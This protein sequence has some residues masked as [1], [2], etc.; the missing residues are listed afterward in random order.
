MKLLST[1]FFLFVTCLAVLQ[2]QNN[3]R[4]DYTEGTSRIVRG[5]VEEKLRLSPEHLQ[6]IMQQR[7]PAEQRRM[8][9]EV[10]KA[11]APS[12]NNKASLTQGSTFDRRVSIGGSEE[13]ELHA[14]VNPTDSN[15][16]VCSAM[17]QAE[18]GLTF[19]MYYT[20]DFGKT[21]HASNFSPAP[22]DLTALVLGGG[23]PM[24]A[25]DANGKLYYSWI[26][27]Y[28]SLGGGFS[29]PPMVMFWASSTDGGANF[30]RLDGKDSITSGFLNLANQEASVLPDKQWMVCDLSSSP[31][32]NNVY[33]SL[34]QY[35]P[36]DQR[37]AMRVKNASDPTFNSTVL[38][39][40][41]KEY[42]FNQFTSI[43]CDDEG[44]P[45]MSFVAALPQD[46]MPEGE[47][48]IYHMSS[49]D[50]GK[51]VAKE[52]FVSSIRFLKSSS[53]DPTPIEPPAGMSR[54]QALPQI[55]CDKSS[56]S[57]FKGNVYLVWTA[58]GVSERLNNGTDIYF[59]RSTDHGKTWSAPRI[60]NND[61]QGKGTTQ[62]YAS[63]CVNQDGRI[64]VCW[65]D[66]SSNASN[67][68][69]VYT[70]AYSFDG[71]LSFLPSFPV[72]SAPTDFS[73]FASDT[74]KAFGM[75]EY[76]QVVCTRGYAI[77]FWGDARNGV[78]Q[79]YCAK[80]PFTANQEVSVPEEVSSISEGFRLKLPQ[81]NPS[82]T[83][84]HFSYALSTA[85]TI[86]LELVDSRGAIVKSLVH[87]S[88]S[89]GEYTGE[90]S[91]TELSS[92]TY[93]LRMR[94]DNA[95]VN[96]KVVVRH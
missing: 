7:D 2:A 35:Y 95:V 73:I 40:T 62:A 64:A 66:F 96:Q 13:S 69:G 54:I 25:F 47:F 5:I 44:V 91:V 14:A 51:T 63:M 61:A 34:L 3:T 8:L 20:K 17:S 32:R 59:S 50:H 38:R 41:S 88:L 10:L 53:G 45:H 19:P 81:P 74:T 65:Y 29:N 80:V 70:M 60:V 82:N 68:Q 90:C 86:S 24:F 58:V 28:L 92:G 93:F 26:D 83:N 46:S 48:R 84:L 71:G 27:L 9:R 15:N 78:R 72:A 94:G 67:T 1:S 18:L 37:V 52:D 33:T 55:A 30:D 16:I 87:A 42:T 56:G 21:W 79:I 75:G 11:E 36:S 43:D 31:G 23:D 39:P 4:S 22:S 89:S 57:A 77:P 76:N 49:P 6:R 12:Q 85:R